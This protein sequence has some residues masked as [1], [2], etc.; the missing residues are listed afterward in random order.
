M[1]REIFKPCDIRNLGSLKA[2]G[3]SSAGTTL[4]DGNRAEL[5]DYPEGIEF[6]GVILIDS[7]NLGDP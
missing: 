6:P 5:E 7:A 2:P 3:P 1:T 4:G